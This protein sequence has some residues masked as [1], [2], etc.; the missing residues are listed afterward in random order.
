MTQDGT[1][2]LHRI[3]LIRG[4]RNICNAIEAALSTTQKVG[5]GP[6]LWR[7]QRRWQDSQ[8]SQGTTVR[9][10][11]VARLFSGL[12]RS[13]AEGC[14]VPTGVPTIYK[15]IEELSRHAKLHLLL[16]AKGGHTS[17][18]NLRSGSLEL[19]G[20]N[21]RVCV[22]NARPTSSGSLRKVT[23]ALREVRHARKNCFRPHQDQARS[24][25][26]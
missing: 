16:L 6:D 13:I 14:W 5:A 21:S 25:L 17:L 22:I 11:Y 9:I 15:M 24:D 19:E 12:E 2:W 1:D 3:L 10:L 7:R 18:V 4:V 8:T 20:L 26:Y 23:S